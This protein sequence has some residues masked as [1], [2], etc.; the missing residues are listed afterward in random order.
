MI[1]GKNFK[2]TSHQRC[3]SCKSAV[4]LSEFH[5]DNRRPSGLRGTCKNCKREKQKV[6]KTTE[7][8]YAVFKKA[9]NKFV[10]TNYGRFAHL[11]NIAKKKGMECTLTLEHFSKLIEKSCEYCG[12]KLEE[13]G[14]GLDRKNNKEGYTVDNVVPCCKICNQTKMDIFSFDEMKEIGKIIRRILDSRK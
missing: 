8:G 10:R 13:T 6:Y 4:L 7:K 1:T 3:C 2:I 12:G 9:S 11:V 14:Y 5:T